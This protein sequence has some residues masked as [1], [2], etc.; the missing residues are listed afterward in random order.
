MIL[1]DMESLTHK[2]R[3]M[4][5]MLVALP[6]TLAIG[7]LTAQIPQNPEVSL[8]QSQVEIIAPVNAQQ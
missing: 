1:T 4:V 3:K 5:F 8:N 6:V 2:Q 7:W